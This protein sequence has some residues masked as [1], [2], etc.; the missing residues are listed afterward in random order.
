MDDRLLEVYIQQLA[1]NGE[2]TATTLQGILLQLK[3]NEIKLDHLLKECEKEGSA[4]ETWKTIAKYAVAGCLALL[5]AGAGWNGIQLLI[6]A[7]IGG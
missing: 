6:N 4:T 1:K 7:L 3:T 5:G 2:L